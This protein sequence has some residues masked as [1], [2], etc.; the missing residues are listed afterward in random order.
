MEVKKEER[1]A[2]K[3]SVRKID[4]PEIFI[5][6]THRGE[7][8]VITAQLPYLNTILFQRHPTYTNCWIFRRELM[9]K[10]DPEAAITGH[11]LSTWKE[12]DVFNELEKRL[13][14]REKAYWHLLNENMK[15]KAQPKRRRKSK[16]G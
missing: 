7:F 10:V 15:L 1:V 3:C 2:G 6:E 14:G 8:M 11:L 4:S 9:G 16:R 13:A 5:V 12:V